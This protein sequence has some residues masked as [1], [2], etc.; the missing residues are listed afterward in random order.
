MMYV[1]QGSPSA[2]VVK[3]ADTEKERQA[4]KVQKAQAVSSPP[5]PGQQPSIF[6]AVPMGYVPAPPPYNGYS[7]QV[8]V[9]ANL[10]DCE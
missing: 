6:G 9:S 4:R 1:I 7:Y 3:W 10:S 5:I 2:L 8:G